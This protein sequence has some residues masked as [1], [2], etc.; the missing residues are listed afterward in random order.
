M[1]SGSGNR[2]LSLPRTRDLRPQRLGHPS[3]GLVVLR[4][5]VRVPWT[6]SLG[7][8]IH[9]VAFPH[10]TKKWKGDGLFLVSSQ[11]NGPSDGAGAEL[12]GQRV[13]GVA[14]ALGLR[15]VRLVEA[16]LLRGVAR[17]EV[18]SGDAA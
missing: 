16:Q 17:D 1:E 5:Y 12:G 3:G 9:E 14:E 4:R 15:A 11:V 6:Y 18:M 10:A 13:D 7:A 8:N 2:R